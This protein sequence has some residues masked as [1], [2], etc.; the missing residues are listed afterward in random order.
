MKLHGRFGM[1]RAERNGRLLLWT[2][3]FFVAL[4]L[5]CGAVMVEA[6]SPKIALYAYHTEPYIDLDPSV[7]YSNGI[8]PLHNVYET[9]TRYNSETGKIDPLLAESWTSEEGGK[10]WTFRMRRGVTF[11]DGSPL[12]ADAVKKSIERTIRMKK[13]A[14]YIWDAV[15]R[16]ETPDD[17]TVVFVLKNPAPVD[18]ISAAS[19][20]AFIISPAAIEKDSAWFNAGNDGGTGPYTIARVQKGEQIILKRFDEYWRGWTEGQFDGV[21]IKKYSESSSRRQLLEK[22][23]AQIVSDLSAS[24]LKAMSSN[25]NLTVHGDPSWKN[26]IGFWNTKKPPLD[27]VDFRRAMCY[28]YPYEEVIDNVLD[29]RGVVATGLIPAGLWSHSDRLGAPTFDMAKAEEYLR[30]SGVDPSKYTL[31]VTFTTGYE[32]YRSAMQIYRANLKKLGIELNIREMTWDN[33]WERSKNKKPE[34]RQDLLVMNWWPD[35]PSPLSWFYS[36]VHSEK[37]IVFNLSYIDDPDLDRMIE[38]ADLK[39]ATDREAAEKLFVD[40][41]EKLVNEAYFLYLFDRVDSW[42]VSNKITGFKSN[43]SYE[44][45][46]FFYD[47]RTK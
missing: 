30:K 19:Y 38:E 8:I 5:F 34:D 24:D 25:P 16:I 12:T 9:L 3:L 22:G 7:E 17:V 37:D 45:V 18:L 11:H 43:P 31:E 26:V 14:S 35:Y 2:L 23:D 28:A 21:I 46:V 6:A 47:L 32:V 40:A 39:T 27:N 10:R 41:Q 33:V 29:G 1:L 42:V 20:A 4:A 36:L 15:E 13:S 44:T